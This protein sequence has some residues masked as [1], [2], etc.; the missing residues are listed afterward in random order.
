MWEFLLSHCWHFSWTNSAVILQKIHFSWQEAHGFRGKSVPFCF[1]L[2]SY[3]KSKKG[4]D[5]SQAVRA[6]VYCQ[7][8]HISV[9][10]FPRYFL[11]KVFQHDPLDCITNDKHRM[12]QSLLYIEKQL[13]EASHHLLYY[14]FQKCWVIWKGGRNWTM[15]IIHQ[16]LHRVCQYSDYQ[17]I[18]DKCF[19]LLWKRD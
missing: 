11:Q 16:E 10:G 14:A 12:P 4:T 17:W 6:C 5:S 1:V 8:F 13:V 3:S 19:S 18:R 2:T 7:N 15:K 9:G